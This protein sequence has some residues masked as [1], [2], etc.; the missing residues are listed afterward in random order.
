MKT[1]VSIG[2]TTIVGWATAVLA[3]L[4]AI[5]ASISEGTVAFNGPEKYLAIFGIAAG[6]ITQVGRYVQS[7]AL[8]KAGKSS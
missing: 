5:V 8:S 7:H 6:L 1:S 3:L 2:P 4:P